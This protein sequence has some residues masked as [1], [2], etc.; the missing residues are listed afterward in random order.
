MTELVLL[1]SIAMLA[2]AARFWQLARLEARRAEQLYQEAEACLLDARI[3]ARPAAFTCCMVGCDNPVTD[4][5][6]R[7]QA[8]YAL[9]GGGLVSVYDVVCETCARHV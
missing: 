2:I 1:A 5:S 9:E 8:T 4:D 7:R 6:P 3:A